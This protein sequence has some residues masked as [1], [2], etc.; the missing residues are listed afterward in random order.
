MIY[1]PA[2]GQHRVETRIVTMQAQE[3][4]AQIGLRLDPVTLGTGEDGEQDGCPRSCLL[5]AEE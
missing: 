2:I 3:N 5:A 1:S 4:L